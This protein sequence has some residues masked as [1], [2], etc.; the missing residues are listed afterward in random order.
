[1]KNAPSRGVNSR[2]GEAGIHDFRYTEI[3]V[4]AL[5]RSDRRAKNSPQGCFSR[6]PTSSVR[7]PAFLLA[8]VPETKNAPSRGV[9]SRGGEA[10]IRTLVTGFTGK[11]VF[12]TAAF[13][14]SAT[15]PQGG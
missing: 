4:L 3:N 10:G 14:R 6:P 15:S 2:G 13:N 12:E 7:T 1:M 9:N 5:A 8:P 11:T